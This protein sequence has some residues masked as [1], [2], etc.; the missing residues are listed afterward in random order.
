MKTGKTYHTREIPAAHSTSLNVGTKQFVDNRS[1][2]AI[3]ILQRQ[4]MQQRLGREKGL[5]LPPQNIQNVV[6]RYVTD[7]T[8]GR[9]R[10]EEVYSY[11]K[12]K[13]AKGS[14]EYEIL[15]RLVE[16]DVCHLLT[17]IPELIR[18]AML[19]KRQASIQERVPS[20]PGGE[21]VAGLET[22]EQNEILE[23]CIGHLLLQDEGVLQAAEEIYTITSDS[24][25]VTNIEIQKRA[26]KHKKTW[27][28]AAGFATYG[29]SKVQAERERLGVNEYV[30]AATQHLEITM[31]E[32]LGEEGYKA[33]RAQYP[34]GNILHQRLEGVSFDCAIESLQPREWP[35]CLKRR[36]CRTYNILHSSHL[37]HE[38]IIAHLQ[39]MYTKKDAKYS[40]LLKALSFNTSTD[41]VGDTLPPFACTS[42]LGSGFRQGQAGAQHTIIINKPYIEGAEDL[43]KP[44]LS[45]PSGTAFRFVRGWAHIMAVK[46]I[47]TPSIEDALLVSMANLLPPNSHHSYHEIMDGVV[48][49]GGLQYADR[50]GYGDL[51]RIYPDLY[52]RAFVEA[53]ENVRRLI[54]EH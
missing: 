8:G 34:E 52:G 24:S 50:S 35:E 39:S 37:T 18:R 45:G 15:T 4:I 26:D 17:D 13:Y 2:S 12:S 16:S 22:I 46:K 41:L 5:Y 31:K 7:K 30:Y 28:G 11:Y 47:S 32:A 51:A 21:Y 44:L 42:G 9:Y 54:L 33:W 36:I 20:K 14:Q 38:R 6:Q 19:H 48:G 27:A 23:E 10:P 25:T 49:I 53:R 29:T 43:K 1:S 3:Q 40:E